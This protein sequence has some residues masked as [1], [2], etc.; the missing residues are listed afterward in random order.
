MDIQNSPPMDLRNRPF[1]Q[2]LFDGQDQGGLP[3]GMKNRAPVCPV[4]RVIR[5]SLH[6]LDSAGS[7]GI[8]DQLV[9]LVVLT[10]EWVA[11]LEPFE[12]SLFD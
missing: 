4:K 5:C 6:Q 12:T 10:G 8:V 7:P 1:Q 9:T 11:S 3:G 2:H